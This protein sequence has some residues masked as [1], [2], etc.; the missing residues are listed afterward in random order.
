MFPVLTSWVSSGRLAVP[1][2]E[3]L[4]LPGTVSFVHRHLD[5]ERF[6]FPAIAAF[7]AAEFQ[8]LP[9]LPHGRIASP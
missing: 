3:R 1:L 2:A 5:T 6:P 7:W 9:A 8:A 4:E